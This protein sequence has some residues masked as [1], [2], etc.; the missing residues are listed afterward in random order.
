MATTAPS[1][2][3][4]LLVGLAVAAVL[5]TAEFL[6]GAPPGVDAAYRVPEFF[7]ILT[8]NASMVMAPFIY[9]A[10]RS[11]D[12][13]DSALDI[14]TTGFLALMPVVSLIAWAGLWIGLD[15]SG[16]LAAHAIVVALIVLAWIGWARVRALTRDGAQRTTATTKHRASIDTALTDILVASDMLSIEQRLSVQHMVGRLREEMHQLTAADFERSP[17][18]LTRIRSTAEQ[19]RAA[20]NGATECE[21]VPQAVEQTRRL[22]ESL[23]AAS[24]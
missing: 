8:L 18:L 20:V 21:L 5:I 16:F 15:F 9:I 22:T 6:V 12:K 10:V 4:T 7:N 13:S 2:T 19:L 3:S 11:A 17:Q 14:G 1:R 23:R 24:Y